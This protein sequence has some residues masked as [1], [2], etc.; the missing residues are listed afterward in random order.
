MGYNLG[1][2]TDDEI[3]NHVKSTVLEYR[4]DINLKDFNK[5]L[6]D[7]IKMTFDT[8]IYGQSLEETITAECIRQID[9]TN[10]NRIGYFHQNLFRYAGGNWVVPDNGQKGGFDIINE[11]KHIFVEMKNK[12]NTLNSSSAIALYMKMQNKILRDDRATCYLVE[13]I[14][15]NS[16]DITWDITINREQY[17]HERIRRI[18]IDRFYE[19]VFDDKFA[20]CKLCRALPI[21]L[22]DIIASDHTITLRNTVLDD[23]NTTSQE[24]K[25]LY[26]QFYL[27]A[28]RTYAGFDHF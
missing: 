26:K 3:F 16:Q 7:P 11:D 17:S 9:K 20:F 22:D 8:K 4:R 10:N 5:N 18:S 2:I 25:E 13:I 12:H 14:A 1:F 6:I 24:P 23:F 27:L 21:I 15:Q 28:F 19:L